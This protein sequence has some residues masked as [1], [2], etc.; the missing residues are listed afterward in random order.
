[1]TKDELQKKIEA[2]ASESRKK[3]D[4]FCLVPK[5]SAITKDSMLLSDHDTTL[6]CGCQIESLY[7]VGANFGI[8]LMQDEVDKLKAENER[9]RKII[10]SQPHTENTKLRQ[11]VE[12][13]GKAL[14]DLIID[15]PLQDKCDCWHHQALMGKDAVMKEIGEM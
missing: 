4:V 15:H 3:F 11:L 8:S 5:D 10:A 6:L 7:K 9:L 1:M 12:E 2:A 14:A 13:M